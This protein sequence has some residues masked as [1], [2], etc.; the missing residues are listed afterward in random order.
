MSRADP[1]LRAGALLY[2]QN[3]N[4]ML[5]T[6]P[7]WAHEIPDLT[8]PLKR[9]ECNEII[10]HTNGVMDDTGVA[11][12]VYTGSQAS[13]KPHDILAAA[14][15]SM[16]ETGPSRIARIATAN[17]QVE[18]VTETL[19]KPG[20]SEKIVAMGGLIVVSRKLCHRFHL[21]D[22]WRDSFDD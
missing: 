20:G 8:D 7:N 22:I 16:P 1:L 14:I 3:G 5:D 21:N 17:F 9:N 19:P 2:G 6:L 11:V 4:Y 18:W 10:L 15:G 13:R 12:R